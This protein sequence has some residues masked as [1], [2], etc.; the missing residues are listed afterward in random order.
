MPTFAIVERLSDS[1]FLT[2]EPF[3]RDDENVFVPSFGLA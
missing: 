1:F 2:L 3:I